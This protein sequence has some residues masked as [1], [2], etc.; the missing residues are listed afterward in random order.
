MGEASSGHFAHLATDGIDPEHESVGGTEWR[1][2]TGWAVWRARRRDGSQG[3]WCATRFRQLTCEE[4]YRGLAR[5]LVC[6]TFEQ[7]RE[8]LIM[9]AKLE[10]QLGP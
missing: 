10:E 3:S 2:F 1:E 4:I 9:Q 7:L 5:T 8:E 6:E